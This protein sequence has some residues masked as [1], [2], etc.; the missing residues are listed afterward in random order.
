MPQCASQAAHRSGGWVCPDKL[1]GKQVI[2]KRN[3]EYGLLFLKARD[4]ALV[5]DHL[6]AR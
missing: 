2:L 1:A 3:V 5:E 6:R 4:R